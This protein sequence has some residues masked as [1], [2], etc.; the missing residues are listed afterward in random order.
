MDIKPFHARDSLIIQNGIVEYE[1]FQRCRPCKPPGM[2]VPGEKDHGNKIHAT[3][4]EM[5]P[6][7]YGLVLRESFRMNPRDDNNQDKE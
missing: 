7:A 1:S 3:P 5:E 4:N 6:R 2:H